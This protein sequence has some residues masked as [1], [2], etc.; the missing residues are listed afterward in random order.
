MI[1]GLLAGAFAITAGKAF[2]LLIEFLA[3]GSVDTAEQMLW[4]LLLVWLLQALLQGSKA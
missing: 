4:Y 1:Q 2:L 3:H